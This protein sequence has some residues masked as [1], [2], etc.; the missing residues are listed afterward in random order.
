MHAAL[1]GYLE[2]TILLL[3][4]GAN[5]NQKDKVIFLRLKLSIVTSLLL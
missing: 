1:K 4:K 5:I 2:I 3:D